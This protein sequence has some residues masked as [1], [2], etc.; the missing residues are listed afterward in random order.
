[1]K[2]M[3]MPVSKL[4]LARVCALLLVLTSLGAQADALGDILESGKIRIGV[5]LFAPWTMETESG[6]LVGFDIDVGRK[7]GDDMGVD[8]EFK[9]YKWEDIISAL[10]KGEI[11]VIAAGMAITPGRAL[12]IS[13]TQGYS[14]AGISLATNTPMTRQIG[15]LEQLNADGI[16][17]AVVKD[18]VS[19]GVSERLFDEAET[20]TYESVAAAQQAV[21]DDQAHAYIG[22]TPLP[23]FMSLQYPSKVDMP[24]Q[25]P[26]LEFK[27]GM[28]VQKGE[29]ELLNFLNS[30]ITARTSDKWIAASHK[31]WFDSL[32]WRNKQGD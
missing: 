12:R 20:R 7:I 11:D 17:I 14:D 32:E 8:V 21:L 24:L 22:A 19:V 30:W 18:T 16:V 15:K 13:F 3:R 31:Y 29:Q 6:S 2:E 28:A 1:M 27:T 25:K 23:K 9:T 10:E 26:L 5:S 4:L